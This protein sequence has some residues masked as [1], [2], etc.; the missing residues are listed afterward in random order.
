MTRI[1]RCTIEMELIEFVHFNFNEDD[2]PDGL[3]RDLAA[4]AFADILAK[5]SHADIEN[6]IQTKLVEEPS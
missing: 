5:Y 4:F 1:I 2:I 6:Y 3:A